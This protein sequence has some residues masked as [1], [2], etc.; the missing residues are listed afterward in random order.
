MFLIINILTYMLSSIRPKISALTMK[1]IIFKFAFISCTTFVEIFPNSIT[2]SILKLTLI[3]ILSFGIKL[4]SISFSQIILKFTTINISTI[5]PYLFSY[6]FFLVILK[7]SLINIIVFCIN[8]NS[9]ALSFI[10]L[11][12]SIMNISL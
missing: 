2:L 4:C 7:L 3:S 6:T 12:L 8:S 5:S 9:I 10:V 1:C 11:P